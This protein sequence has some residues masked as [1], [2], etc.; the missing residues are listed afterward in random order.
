MKNTLLM[1]ATINPSSDF[2]TIT[3]RDQRRKQYYESLFY[4]ICH[5]N[6]DQIVFCE[7]SAASINQSFWHELAELYHKKLEFLIYQ[8]MNDSNNASKGY[9]ECKL[10]DYALRNSDILQ[11]KTQKFYKVTGRVRLKNVNHLLKIHQND[12]NVFIR[13]GISNRDSF[14]TRFFKMSCHM[15]QSKIM[16]HINK[17]NDKG[18]YYMEHLFY[19]VF[20]NKLSGESKTK[21]NKVTFKELPII[22]GF[23]G[24]TGLSY[25]LSIYKRI[26]KSI[27]LRLGVYNV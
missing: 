17:I 20:N 23:S 2:L 25:D 16:Q 21:Y 7:N 6:F 14:D 26:I 12:E 13:S 18:G 1:T 27:L 10:I 3:D 15:Y 4:W 11:N 8:Q 24:S 9:L 5:S 19:D 22:I